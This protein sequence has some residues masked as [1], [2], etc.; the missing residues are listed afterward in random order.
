M[1][2]LEE[3]R[4]QEFV[5]YRTLRRGGGSTVLA[6]PSEFLDINGVKRGDRVKVVHK[7][8]NITI[9]LLVKPKQSEE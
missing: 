3:L 5:T 7:G 4:D 1:K 2:N 9:S 6:I 8:P